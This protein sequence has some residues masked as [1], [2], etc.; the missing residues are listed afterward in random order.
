[1]AEV[2]RRGLMPN[3][4]PASV[5]EGGLAALVLL[6]LFAKIPG[7]SLIPFSAGLAIVLFPVVLPYLR[8]LNLTRQ[9]ACAVAFA[10]LT[11]TV[12]RMSAPVIMGE[13]NSVLVAVAVNLW[14][15]SIPF[16]LALGLWGFQHMPVRT[17]LVLVAAGMSASVVAN[18]SFVAGSGALSDK[19]SLEW[20]GTLGIAVTMLALCLVARRGVIWIRVV[21]L[22]ATMIDVTSDARSQAFVTAVVFACTFVG[23]RVLEFAKNRPRLTAAAIVASLLAFAFS[24]VSAMQAGWLGSEIQRRTIDQTRG[25]QDVITGGR[26]E[27]AATLHLFSVSPQGYGAGIQV[28]PGAQ[29]AAL[30]AVRAVGG[31]A[32]SAYF[33]TQVFGDRTD[34]HSILANM[35]FHFGVGG[36]VVAAVIAIIIA[37]ALPHALSLVRGLGAAALFAMLVATWDLLFSP[38]GNSDRL[39]L[40]VLTAVLLLTRDNRIEW[41]QSLE[42]SE[43]TEPRRTNSTAADLVQQ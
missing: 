10:L 31:D 22:G 16:I 33:R 42:R 1:V 2:G 15:I 7:L 28:D 19:G 26:A 21:L 3:V 12:L 9:L 24:A 18:A 41:C 11:G 13:P 17:G 8:S 36:L 40:G 29:G 37:V 5:V 43:V 20:K 39:I 35:W 32:D 34:L 25:G 6:S 4:P 38:M 14:L 27:W 23:Q 30:S